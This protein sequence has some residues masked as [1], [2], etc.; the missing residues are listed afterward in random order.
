MGEGTPRIFCKS[1]LSDLAQHQDSSQNDT[2]LTASSTPL[3]AYGKL[4][5]VAGGG[6]IR[7]RRSSFVIFMGFI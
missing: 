2:G 4:G 5:M 7:G 3:G 1:S 6:E